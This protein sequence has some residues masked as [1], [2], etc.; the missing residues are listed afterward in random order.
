[1]KKSGMLK[2]AECSLKGFEELLEE[3]IQ[4]GDFDSAKQEHA[5]LAGALLVLKSIGLMP[6]SEADD[7]TE[8]AFKRYLDAKYPGQ[9]EA[10]DG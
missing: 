5:Y 8:A 2:S 9:E 1:M 10:E 4:K 7:R 3:Y 6:T